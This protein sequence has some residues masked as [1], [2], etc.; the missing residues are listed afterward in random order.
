MTQG[1]CLWLSEV[2]ISFNGFSWVSRLE[3]PHAGPIH[4]SLRRH[5]LRGANDHIRINSV[6]AYTCG[7][8]CNTRSNKSQ[9]TTSRYVP[10][11]LEYWTR[12]ECLKAQRS[13]ANEDVADDGNCKMMHMYALVRIMIRR[14]SSLRVYLPKALELT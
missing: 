5:L 8:F 12:V 11:H 7:N 2:L 3:I 1:P 10:A 9:K 4:S 6:P 13:T 14:L